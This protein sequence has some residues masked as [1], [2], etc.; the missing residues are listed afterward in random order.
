MKKY[1]AYIVLKTPLVVIQLV[2]LSLYSCGQPKSHT[3]KLEALDST[4]K[5]SIYNW[6]SFRFKSSANIDSITTQC[7]K[8]LVV[9][10]KDTTINLLPLETGTFVLKFLKL[11]IAI[12]SFTFVA[13][14]NSYF[15]EEWKKVKDG[16]TPTPL[17]AEQYRAWKNYYEYKMLYKKVPDF[18][19]V[20]VYGDSLTNIN[21]IGKTTVINFWEHGCMPCMAE[22]P[23]LNK[24]K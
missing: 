7:E 24:L 12:D 1:L 9:R 5:T 13:S 16:V 18:K 19:T 15:K 14:T 8:R 23:Y 11:G 17:T 21:F 3:I 2:F 4:Q 20:N 22:I 6:T 10:W